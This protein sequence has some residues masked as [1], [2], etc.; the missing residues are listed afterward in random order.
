LAKVYGYILLILACICWGLIL[1]V[2]ALGF[3]AG[4]IAGITTALIII[5]E[6]F[7]WLSIVLLGNE[8][9]QKFKYT[10]NPC[11]WFSRKKSI[12]QIE[13]RKA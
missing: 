5:G 10:L 2:P 7:F 4:W 12:V 9:Y 3:S 11:N 8:F 6:V 1:V 13:R